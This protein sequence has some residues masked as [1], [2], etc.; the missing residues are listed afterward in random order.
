MEDTAQ[1]PAHRE[2]FN[3]L[4]AL[5]DIREHREDLRH[6][7]KMCL[8]QSIINR[9]ADNPRVVKAFKSLM[10]FSERSYQLLKLDRQEERLERDEARLL[11]GVAG[12]A[13]N[14]P[15]FEAPA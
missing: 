2:S 10:E 1:A 12:T 7:R 6:A 15:A 14:A 4:A 11:N 13:A 9:N 8:Y 3:Q 5:D